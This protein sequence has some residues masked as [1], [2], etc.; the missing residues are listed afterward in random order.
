MD[1]DLV[2]LSVLLLDPCLT[3]AEAERE[4]VAWSYALRMTGFQPV[5]TRD[6]LEACP[7]EE[8]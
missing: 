5:T 2:T 7:A 6:R 3:N 8:A 4:A 1:C